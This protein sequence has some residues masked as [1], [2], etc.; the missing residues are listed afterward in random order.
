M[1]FP[2]LFTDR[3]RECADRTLKDWSPEVWEA[4]TGKVLSSEDSFMRERQHFERVH[5]ADWIVIAASRSDKHPGQVEA[6]A[7]LGGRRDRS[8]R[9]S[10]LV[11]CGEYVAGRHG[12][13]ID[14]ARH[15]LMP[16]G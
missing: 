12:F 6:V 7:A 3:E 13:V 1:G 14:L 15:A 9:R 8:E 2:D 16:T 11:P 5:A 4:F 10:F